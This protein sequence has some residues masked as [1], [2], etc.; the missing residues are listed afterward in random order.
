MRNYLAIA[1]C[2]LFSLNLL[3]QPATQTVRGKVVEEESKIPMIGVAVI[4]T[5]DEG[6]TKGTV[7]DMDGFYV[8]EKVPLGRHTVEFRY[9][10]RERVFL[11]N[12]IVNS[13]KEEILDIEMV[14]TA[15]LLDTVIEVKARRWGEANNQLAA[16]SA[17]PFDKEVV[18]RYAGS[19]D[20]PARM[21]ANFAGI[22]G[23]DD[24][25][26]DLVIRGN[27]PQGV[28]WRFEGVNI[29]NPN[30]FAIP[31]TTGGPLAIL[32]NKYLA[33]SDF[34]TG[35]FPAEY[36]NG[37]AGVFDVRM[38]N[39]NDRRHEISAQ[40]GF[41]GTE[42]T[43]EGPLDRD[44]R[45]TYLG[46]YRYSTLRLFDAMGIPI[47]TG[48]TPVYQDGAFRV[49]F[50]TKEGGN[51]A[52]WG[53]G[54]YSVIDVKNSELK[55]P[56]DYKDNPDL[57]A[58]SDRDQHFGS[59]MGVLGLTYT[60]PMNNSA[61]FKATIAASDQAVMGNHKKIFR[62][63]EGNLFV[64]DSLVPNLDFLTEESKFS[65]YLF[66]NRNFGKKTSF[67]AGLNAD[68]WLF[69][70]VDSSK[71]ILIPPGYPNE[72]PVVDDWRVRWDSRNVG[73]IML[74]PYLQLRHRF[75]P[76]FS[77]TAGLTSLYFGLNDN[78][79]SPVEPRLG[80]VYELSEAQ[81]LSFGYG[82]H[83]Q[84]APPYMYFYGHETIG[85]DPQEHNLD[86][87]LF[88]SHHAV[89]SYDWFVG[90]LLRFKAETY[91]QYLFDI[92]VE[93]KSSSFSLVNTGSGF[94]R[95]FPDTLVNEGTA[96][97]YGIEVSLERYF[98]QG[99]YFLITG[100]VFDAQYRGSDDVLRRT[101][102]N[103]RF[104][105]NALIARE[106]TFDNRSALNI[107]AKVTYAGGRWRGE[108]DKAAS[109]LVQD[110]VYIDST[111]NTIQVRP[112]FRTDLKVSYRWN[113]P[114][115][116]HEF[117]LDLVNLTNYKNLLLLTYVQDYPEGDYIQETYQLG[118]LPI[119]YYKLEFGF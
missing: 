54:G 73:A 79:F 87:G 60:V 83:S 68:Y 119:F 74:Q 66:Y 96:R 8:L 70:Q 80:F 97:N 56:D 89:L 17:I 110:I 108:V 41:L 92:P 102:F 59:R 94:D 72:P 37:V 100:S 50:P 19:R 12:V 14:E 63:V 91:Y 6:D 104:V 113:R 98:K 114:K 61:F 13:G 57:Y 3:A 15:T 4:L 115:V 7:T 18:S 11:N 90:K 35:A 109:N 39:G 46:S 82:L 45:Y 78:S 101:T 77:A 81:K 28:L 111:M 32:N 88:K 106:F 95:L 47:G 10:G 33:N 55:S 105:T 16:V 25:R 29:P 2:A 31:G 22:Q 52:L 99:Y 64:L 38:R 84:I 51:I 65:A 44:K 116:L 107:G 34:F 85:R 58:E 23:A 36:A 30:H 1:A 118:F 112:Y 40:L 24:S 86:I 43:A 5:T 49:N 21:A 76:K 48:A 103:S 42:L 20:D 93:K 117:S 67:K 71:L 69:N 9:V 53:I 62:H 75:G 27:T 26:N